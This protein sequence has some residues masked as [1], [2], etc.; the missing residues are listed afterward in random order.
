VILILLGWGL[1]VLVVH[2][3]GGAFHSHVDRP[4]N[5]WAHVHRSR[6]V[7]GVLSRI[8]NLGSEP[9]LAAVVLVAGLV[10]AARRRSAAPLLA[11]GLAY[12]GGAAVTLAVKLAVQRGRSEIAHGLAGATQLAFPSGHATLGAA[13]Y[14]TA[15]ILLSR[16]A[17]HDPTTAPSPPGRWRRTTAAAGLVVLAVTIGAARVYNGQHDT[18]D[19]LAGWLLGALWARAVTSLGRDRGRQDSAR[20]GRRGLGSRAGGRP[21]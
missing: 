21:R 3:A 2:V 13:V 5:H 12:A 19:V 11:L 18:T 10:W 17:G 7:T 20:P 4:V 14:G 6:A 15:A 16:P 1:G 8:A 9:V